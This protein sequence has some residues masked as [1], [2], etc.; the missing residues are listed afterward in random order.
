MLYATSRERTTE[1]GWN[2]K[3][4]MLRKFHDRLGKFSFQRIKE[5]PENADCLL[6][7]HL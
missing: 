2:A 5:L 7:G 6:N 4:E 3:S 1:G